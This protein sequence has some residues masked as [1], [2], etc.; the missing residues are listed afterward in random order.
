MNIVEFFKNRKKNQVIQK[1]EICGN[2]LPIMPVVKSVPIRLNDRFVLSDI[3]FYKGKE[4][5]DE[6][7]YKVSVRPYIYNKDNSRMVSVITGIIHDIPERFHGYQGIDRRLE[8][9]Q[10]VLREDLGVKDVENVDLTD[11]RIITESD[12]LSQLVDH[13]LINPDLSSI[14]VTQKDIMIITS[15]LIKS[16]NKELNEE[17]EM[18]EIISVPHCDK[19]VKK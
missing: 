18:K 10:K 17:K 3:H 16:F 8:I 6:E 13:N 9:A 12:R 7:D 5:D 1:S 4:Y 14:L 19:E 2:V 15:D 11:G